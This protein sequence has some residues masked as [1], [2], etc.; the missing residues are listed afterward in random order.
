MCRHESSI[1]GNKSFL[2]QKVIFD[3][4]GSQHYQSINTSSPE[5]INEAN[6]L[7]GRR[8]VFE[9]SEDKSIRVLNLVGKTVRNEALLH[10]KIGY[11]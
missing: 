9:D 6:I 4:L 1:S 10:S 8:N 7:Q 5:K 3:T 11:F 2:I